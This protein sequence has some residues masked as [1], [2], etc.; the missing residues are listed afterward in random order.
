MIVRRSPDPLVSAMFAAS[1]VLFLAVPAW[2]WGGW[3]ALVSHPARAMACLTLFVT[4]IVALFSGVNIAGRKRHASKG[5][6]LVAPSLLVTLV[7]AWLPAYWDRRDYWT[8]DGDAT[9]YVGLA[10]LIL[11]CVLRV[12]PMFVLG[13]RFSWPDAVQE[14]HQL[15]TTGF[16]RY[17]RHPSYLG[18]ILGGAGW[19]LVFRNWIGVV[20]IALLL[21]IAI[22][23][24]RQEEAL[25]RSEFGADYEAY[26]KRTWWIVPFVI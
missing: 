14:E 18:A 11:G 5:A 24:V 22:P 20:L 26:R 6:W 21:L 8:L 13:N 15:T 4:T 3:G 7:T 9:R 1:V 17:I 10:L 12:G 2:G 16:Y 19:C 25:L 23:Y